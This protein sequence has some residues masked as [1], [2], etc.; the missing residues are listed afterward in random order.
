MRTN[1]TGRRDES[2]SFSLRELQELEQDRIAREKRETVERHAAL[3]RE[4]EDR[5]RREAMERAER[6]R[7]EE[8]KREAE[9]RRE[10]EDL[11]RREAMQKAIVEQ[12]RVEVEARTRAEE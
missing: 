1:M 12:A 4:R 6:E 8:E 7:H 5:A 10:L 3:A 2:V 11:A 9:R